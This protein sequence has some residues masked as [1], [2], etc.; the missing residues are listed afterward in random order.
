M[1]VSVA[2]SALAAAVVATA[3]AMATAMAAGTTTEQGSA[4]L[5]RSKQATA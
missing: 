5:A 3:M 2:T 4:K 1:P